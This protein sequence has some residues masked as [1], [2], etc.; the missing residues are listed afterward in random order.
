MKTILLILIS[1]LAANVA[2]QQQLSGTITDQKGN[3][4]AFANIYIE[5]S[6]DGTTSDTLGRFILHTD[7]TG[8]LLFVASFIGYEK[9]SREVDLDSGETDMT[10]NLKEA[11][12]ELNEVSITAGTFSASYKKNPPHSP[13][14]TLPQRPVPWGTFT[15]PMPPCQVPRR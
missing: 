15:G 1:L 7:L 6:Y 5:G 14:L 2:G 9:Y 10:I 4:V 8:K 3:P 12:S 13:P 11:V